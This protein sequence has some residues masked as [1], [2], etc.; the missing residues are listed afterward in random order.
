MAQKKYVSI[1]KLG[2]YHEKEVAR[3]NG[4]IKTAKDEAIAH[5]D[6]LA[7]NYDVAGAAATVQ[8]KLD[9]EVTRAKAAEEAAQ[10]AA[11]KAQGEVDALE[12]VVATKAAQSDLDAV[13]TKIGEVPEDKTVKEYIDAKTEGIASEEALGELQ[14]AVGALE[15]NKA[16]KTQV[17]T[18]IAAAVKVETDAR[19]EA[20]AGVQSAVDTLAGTHATDKEALEDA[21]AL[22]ADIT[23]LNE[24]SDVANAA[25][26]QTDY[27]AKV[28]EL[29]AED[30]RIAGLVATEKE[31]AEG[32][33]A[34]IEGRL[35]EVEAFFKLAEGE[36]LDTALDTLKELQ[37]VINGEGAVADQ[38]LLDIAANKK[39]IEEHVATNH[40]FAG[41]DATLKA[42]LEGQIALKA[43]KSTV[44]GIDGRLET[45]E[46][47]IETLEG[48]MAEV[49][50]A[51]AT[52]AEA[53]ALADEVTAR[54]N[55]DTALSDRIGVLEGKFTEGEGSVE[56]MIADAIAEEVTRVDGELA[57]KVDKVDGKGLSTNDL[58]NEL[59]AQ[60]DEAYAHSQVAHAPADA[61]KNVIET[62]K[63]N[64][65]AVTVTDK[66]VD[67]AVP[68]DNAQL[69]NGA[70]YLV[71]SDI[72]NKAD[73]ATTL[74]GYGIADAYTS[75]E[76]DTAI[77]NAV[78]QFVECSEEEIN[79]LFA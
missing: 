65:T 17:V 56:D 23:A 1:E 33:E 30:A 2:L 51:V 4:L 9:E 45:A 49:Q 40:D 28:A 31:R 54:T 77:A 24:V 5:A 59:K 74:A 50:G 13:V 53:Q 43:D 8:G 41:A 25:V 12:E 16:D 26:K 70:G 15:T 64:G 69:L 44:E 35:E 66:A 71:A 57:K 63:V 60:Y 42:E 14:E 10:V 34:G 18:D 48:D 62:V 19:V 72:A 38:M 29:V 52:K 39:V 75:A 37:D 79:A 6:S 36:Q 78:G 20:I 73:K 11:D 68:T 61:Q 21:I 55:A 47:K 32:V 22:K 46:G 7:S 27:D 67:I 3:V 58:T 76:T